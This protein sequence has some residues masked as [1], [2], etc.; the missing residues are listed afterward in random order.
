[1]VT[2]PEFPG[3]GQ[4]HQGTLH[5]ALPELRDLELPYF[6][7]TG[8][9]DGPLTTIVAGVHGCEYVS[10]HAATRLAREIDPAG[11]TGRLL[12]LPVVNLPAFQERTPFVNPRDG[13]NP[14]R[15]F[16][17]SPDG[18]YSDQLAHFVFSTCIEPAQALLDLHGGDMVEE[19]LPFAIYAA[20]APPAVT[21]RSRELAWAF[22]LPYTIAKRA[23]PGT[24]AGM[25][26]AAAARAGVPGLIAEA[27]GIGQ[28]TA[29]DVELLMAGATR[30]LHV[31]GHVPRASDSPGTAELKTFDWLYSQSAG[32]WIANVRAGD[33][34][35]P[36]QVLGHI[37]DLYGETRETISAPQAGIVIFRT[38]S[39]AMKEQGLLL[40]IGS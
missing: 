10:I 24:L 19:L 8:R 7:L 26:Y 30:A 37:L 21:S 18:S 6:A 17:G 40:G 14:N 1:M 2:R 31:L 39:A 23:E 5:S 35:T 11:L 33:L 13:K 20:D 9:T 16:P 28:L 29:E 22:G 3:P 32:F 12:V 15:V 38:T 4:R 36:G 25:T 34:V 27:G